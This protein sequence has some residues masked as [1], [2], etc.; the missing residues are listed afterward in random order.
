F[1][2]IL[3]HPQIPPNTGNA[4]R[5]CANSGARLHL[6]RPLGFQLDDK[7]LRRAGLDYHEYADLAVHDN[8]DSC[9]A[10]LG[11]V[12]VFAL[13][14]HAHR[15]YTDVCYQAGDALLFGC[16]TRGLGPEL[17]DTIDDDRK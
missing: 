10:T 7:R 3:H 13:T 11:S 17:L 12:R 16:E 4:I 15:W 8:L 1:H 2:V 5:L 14:K 9:L 6:I